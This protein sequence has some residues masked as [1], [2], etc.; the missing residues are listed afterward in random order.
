MAQRKLGREGATRKALF[1]NLANSLFKNGRVETTEPKAK[2]VARIAE[3]LITKA[4]KGT[5]HA[6][7]QVMSKLQDQE[8]VEILFDDLASQFDTRT[9]GYTRV[10]KLGPR[11]GDGSPMAILELVE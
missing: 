2:E 8:S 3:K 9:G 10:I 7:R 4:K 1:V 11:R 5:Q 6:R